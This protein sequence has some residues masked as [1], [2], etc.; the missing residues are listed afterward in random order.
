MFVAA[1]ALRALWALAL[2]GLAYFFFRLHQVRMRTRELSTKYGVPILP[3]SY[4][5]GHLIVMGKAMSRIP[6]D[7]NGTLL[8]HFL[9]KDFPE[10]EE[11]GA[12][13]ID[14]WP[15]VQPLVFVFNPEM[16]S[17]FT[18]I[19]SLPKSPDMR[20][21]FRPWT[22]NLDLVTLDGPEWKRWR[23]IFNPS[24]SNKNLTSLAPAMLKEI[25]IFSDELKA[26]ARSGKTVKLMDLAIDLTIDVI[27]L[28]ISGDR[29][30]CQTTSQ[31]LQKALNNQIWWTCPRS[32]PVEICKMLH[33][34]RSL[35]IWNNNRTIKNHFMPI[36]QRLINEQVG[37]NKG[38]GAAGETKTILALAI[39][40]YLA[41]Q[42]EA[43]NP[44]TS[45]SQIDSAF[46]E[47]LTMHLGMIFF[48]G[49]DTTAT[50]LC[51]AVYMLS[52]HPAALAAV[53][54]EHTAVLGADPAAAETR[55]AANPTLLNSL[56][57]TAAVIKE[58]TRLFPAVGGSVRAG[59]PDFWLVDAK[60]GQRMPTE[61]WALFSDHH[62]T[63]HR[64]SLWPRPL[65]FIPERFLVRDGDEANPLRPHK[66]AYRPFELGPRGCIGLELV[67]LELKAIL[68]LTA[69]EMDFEGAFTP[70]SPEVLGHH[71]YHVGDI[72]AHP[73]DGMPMRVKLRKAG[74]I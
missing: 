63:H 15:I 72:V 17:T 23:S 5:W 37:N 56:P 28:N 33:P 58:T 10:F 73:K 8:M 51:Y 32:T 34:L 57:Y 1:V 14:S 35:F 52:K 74:N 19:R 22:K 13:Y 68:A 7:A 46:L 18:Q 41:E 67:Q 55:I 2:S 6:G 50:T 39:Q 12:V 9:L 48:A 3:H 27:A 11:H 25:R 4:F 21:E 64:E 30:N 26:A 36:I 62:T 40:A 47:R 66:N 44:I 45:A 29:L 24:F 54:A 38:V 71:A 53:R 20:A 31:P 65:D 60:T 16:I 61:H 49:H 59:Q 70:G 43:G 42:K 69:R